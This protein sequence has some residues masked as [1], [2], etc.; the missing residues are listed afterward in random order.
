MCCRK[1]ELLLLEKHEV[2]FP[3]ISDEKREHENETISTEHVMYILQMIQYIGNLEKL[4][5]PWPTFEYCILQ[6]TSHP[7]TSIA[8][9]SLI[10]TNKQHR[11][12]CRSSQ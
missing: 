8:L 9:P 4:I 12:I 5:P 10:F 1:F 6:K 11:I 7:C 3:S 2:D